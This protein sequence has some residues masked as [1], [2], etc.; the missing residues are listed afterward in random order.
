[1]SRA[2]KG[3]KISPPPASLS[4]RKVMLLVCYQQLVTKQHISYYK[5]FSIMFP[6]SPVRGCEIPSAK[7]EIPVSCTTHMACAGTQ[8]RTV[9]MGEPCSHS[10]GRL[11]PLLLVN[12]D[13]GGL[14]EVWG[15]TGSLQHIKAFTP[16]FVCEQSFR[17]H[18]I[19]DV[20]IEL[21]N[22]AINSEE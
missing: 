12:G 2:G 18:R 16:A 9:G 22:G 17:S 4:R 13:L 14:R 5:R 20:I 19:T 8:P 1:M 15:R 7:H 6:S 3:R 11:L 21:E 10:W